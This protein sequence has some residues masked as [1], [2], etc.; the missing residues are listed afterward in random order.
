M[1]ADGD[2]LNFKRRARCII[3]GII[4]TGRHLNQAEHI[5]LYN[6]N[7]YVYIL[8]YPESARIYDSVRYL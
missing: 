2:V 5:I 1:Y 7:I 8:R 4:G 6:I 3:L